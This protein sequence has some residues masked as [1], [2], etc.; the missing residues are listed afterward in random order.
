MKKYYI[1][2]ENDTLGKISIDSGV[3]LG[4]LKRINNIIDINKIKLG[5]KI[6]T[7]KEAALGFQVLLLDCDNNPIK[8]QKYFLEHNRRIT[9]GVTGGNGLT[10]KIVTDD[11]TD[12]V[13]ISISR[14]DESRKL[15]ATVESGIGNKLV[16]IISPK[17]KVIGKTRPHPNMGGVII[18]SGK[19]KIEPLHDR[20]KAQPST[21]GKTIFG[22]VAKETQTLEGKPLI[23]VEGD[24][25]NFDFL[26]E[27]TGEIMREEDYVWAASEL[28]LELEIIKAFAFVESHGEG[29]FK[30]GKRCLPKILY[31]RHIFARLTGNKY[32]KVYPDISLPNAYYN[33]KAKY[34]LADINYKKRHGVPA[35]ISYY[36]PVLKTD[37]DETKRSATD[38]GHL[39][40]EGKVIAQNDKYLNDA[41][42]Y[43][44]LLKAYQLDQNAALSSCSWGAFQI[45]GEFWKTM[46]YSSA[47]E[48][49]KAVSRSAREQIKAYVLYMKYVNPAIKNHLKRHDW[50]AAAKAFNGPGYK[51]FNYDARIESEYNR[52]KAEKIKR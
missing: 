15:L 38:F 50:T 8:E 35:D 29:F 20:K 22:P 48:F 23:T 39:L 4:E 49:S 11:P 7:D 3:P 5:Q 17:F 21:D 45:L 36:R 2:R 25:P 52:L 30:I 34:V 43:K 14:L 33:K 9:T 13:S 42:S 16:T 46:K 10:K 27:Y 41:G 6:Y 26:D 44:R 47:K 51:D 28:D 12:R 32:S 24:I 1:V 19:D 31:E 18:G 40:D 37:N